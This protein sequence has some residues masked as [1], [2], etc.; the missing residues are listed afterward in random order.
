MAT[1][2]AP[3]QTSRPGQVLGVLA[4]G[5]GAFALLQT[6]VAPALPVLQHDLHTSTSGAAWVFTSFLLASSVATP[7]AGRL[8]DMFGKKRVLVISLSTLAAGSLLAA[9]VTSLP[10]LVAARS[11]QGLGGAIY[12]LAFGIIRDEFPRERV[13]SAI[14]LVSSLLGI[15]GGLGIVLAGP[16]LQHLSYHWLFWILLVL[17]S[18]A[19][20]AAVVFIPE[21]PIR[22]PGRVHWLGGVL[23]SAWLVALLVAVSQGSTWHWGSAKTIGLFV[24]AGLL[25]AGWIKAESRS[26]QPLVDMTMMRLSGVWTTNTAALLLGFGQYGGLILIPQ[27]VQAPVSTGYG[28]GASVTQAGLFLVPTTIASMIMSPISGRLSNRVGS[29]VPLVLGSIVSTIAFV[30]LAVATSRWEIYLASTLIGIGVGLAFASMAHLIVEAVPPGQTGVAT[31]M[32]TIVRTIGG[33][34]GAD[35]AASILGAH[36]LTSGEPA[37]HGYT[38]T[39]SICAAVLLAGV[40]ASLAV[41]GRRRQQA[42]PTVPVGGR[43]S[44]LVER[45]GSRTELLDRSLSRKH[46]VDDVRHR[47]GR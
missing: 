12:P 45:N 6:I 5:C 29:K 44:G 36:L 16:I 8:G 37:K 30:I 11:I 20:V 26:R 32:N 18:A 46:L 7:I 1:T 31:G 28:Y 43:L 13:A 9:V 42:H 47:D 4:L 15:G 10:M 38:I 17:T 14:A 2:T 35:I 23:L 34:I 41:P 3:T 40:L 21:S 24:V 33:A 22:E 25:A 27:F 39:F 19:A